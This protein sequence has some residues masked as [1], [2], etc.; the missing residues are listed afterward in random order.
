M[1][2]TNVITIKSIAT[3]GKR[4]LRY[5]EINGEK[6][7]DIRVW[8][9]DNY[10]QGVRFTAEELQQIVAIAK[11]KQTDVKFGSK[12]L[13]MEKDEY[14]V[15]VVSN[16]RTYIRAFATVDE[17]SKLSSIMEASNNDPL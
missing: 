13:T 4:E 7:Y 16:G 8:N 11:G 12:M 14:A 2:K 3:L 1:A 17:M 15:S 6:K 9:G 10:E 5:T